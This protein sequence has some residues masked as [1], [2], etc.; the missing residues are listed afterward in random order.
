MTLRAQHLRI[1]AGDRLLVPSMTLELKPGEC[2]ALL[3]RNGAGKSLLLHTLAGLR[4]PAGGSVLLEDRPLSRWPRRALACRIALLLQ[5]EPDTFW[6]TVREYVALG[7]LPHGDADR[8]RVDT[9]LAEMELTAFAERPYRTLSGGERQR[10]RLAQLMVQ[11]PTFALLDEPLN[12]LDLRHE[13]LVMAQTAALAR[14]GKAVLCSLHDP[15]W[16][17]RYC[18]HALLLYDSGLIDRGPV[19]AVV[20]TDAI[21]RLYGIEPDRDHL[22]PAALSTQSSAR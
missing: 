14:S 18:S 13:R 5:D 22:T 1:E 6:G 19:S 17:R 11:N 7:R 8:M 16:A 20:T 21:S 3:G 9:T 4:P 12:H 10:V 2:W 15:A